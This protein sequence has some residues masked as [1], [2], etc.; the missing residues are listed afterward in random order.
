MSNPLNTLDRLLMAV[1]FA[2]AGETDTAMKMVDDGA[3][4]NRPHSQA[5]RP[6]ILPSPA[7]GTGNRPTL[8]ERL[9][10]M[11]AAAAFAEAGEFETARML[12][13]ERRNILLVLHEAEPPPGVLSTALSMM[14]RLEAG[15][16][17]LL[18]MGEGQRP[19]A[20]SH[21]LEEV[22]RN[23][24][25]SRLLYRPELSWETVVSHA[26]SVPETV[27]ILVESLE[28][29]GLKGN[30]D[31]RRSPSWSNRLPCP[32]VVTAIG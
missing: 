5:D 22:A 23:G 19:P 31:K 9:E 24:K 10:K 13:Q 15:V 4:V 3:A 2:E 8:S 27:C 17:I 32:L 30:P 21:F 28:R 16:E 6:V 11:W 20:L 26:R 1:T 25:N 18:R 14:E 12:V 29:W 7:H